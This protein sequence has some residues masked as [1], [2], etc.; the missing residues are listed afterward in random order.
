M[1]F[2]CDSCRKRFEVAP[3]VTVTG[4]RLCAA[5]D[6]Q[7]LGMTAGAVLGGPGDGIA[8]GLATAGWYARVKALTRKAKGGG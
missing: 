6:D 8:G 5:C 2:E 3:H 4:R 1:A 7:L